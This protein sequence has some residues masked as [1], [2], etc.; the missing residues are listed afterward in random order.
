M[1]R[2][3][4]NNYKIYK[5]PLSYYINIIAVYTGSIYFNIAYEYSKVN[6]LMFVIWDSFELFDKNMTKFIF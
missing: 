1:K 2:I 3:Y 5:T 6:N 4:I